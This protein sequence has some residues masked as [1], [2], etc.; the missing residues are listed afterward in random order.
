M[1]ESR[2]YTEE[3][4]R[5]AGG[6]LYETGERYWPDYYVLLLSVRSKR[7]QTGSCFGSI[8]AD[9]KTG[10]IINGAY[11]DASARTIMTYFTGASNA[12]ELV[13]ELVQGFFIEGK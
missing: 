4:I 12:N 9:L 6:T 5:M 7:L 13:I 10:T 1:K 3:K 11:H 2:E 8:V